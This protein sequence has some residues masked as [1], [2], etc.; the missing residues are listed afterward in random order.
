MII[1]GVGSMVGKYPIIKIYDELKFS[2]N[3]LGC[4]LIE[5]TKNKLN[6]GFYNISNKKIHNFSVNKY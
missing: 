3:E 4:C 1:S 2:S 5:V 6:I